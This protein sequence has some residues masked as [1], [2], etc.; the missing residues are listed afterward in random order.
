MTNGIGRCGHRWETV[1]EWAI[2]TSRDELTTDTG[3]VT[4][5]M[6]ERCALCGVERIGAAGR[7]ILRSPYP[8]GQTLEAA[9]C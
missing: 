8:C 1:R 5:L 2:W 4:R 3:D 6:V 7:P 9:R